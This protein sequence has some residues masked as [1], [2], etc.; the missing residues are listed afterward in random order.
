MFLGMPILIIVL[1]IKYFSQNKNG[2][3]YLKS[4]VIPLSYLLIM[5]PVGFTIES[6]IIGGPIFLNGL[7]TALSIISEAIFHNLY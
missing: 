2:K 7:Q 5:T 6:K 4:L 3:E 1:S